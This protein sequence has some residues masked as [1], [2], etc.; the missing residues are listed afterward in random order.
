MPAGKV[1][2]ENFAPNWLPRISS[3]SDV[4]S[5]LT[6]DVEC[7]ICIK[8]LA[9]IEP[10]NDE[11]VETYTI[12]PCGHVFSYKCAK[13]WLN[14]SQNAN[15][16]YCRKLSYHSS[17]RH[18]VTLR[19]FQFQPK[20]GGNL[21]E[22]IS[23]CVAGDDGLPPKCGHCLSGK[24]GGGSDEPRR[25]GN[26]RRGRVMTSDDLTDMIHAFLEDR[27]RIEVRF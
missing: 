26:N 24:A 18:V 21:Q 14:S 3:T 5:D 10:L 11:D 4:P 16:P 8:K 13:I 20:N 2:S 15:C 27:A 19:F 1:L 22:A 9:I 23:E 17:C 6:F 25:A 12:L 7:Q